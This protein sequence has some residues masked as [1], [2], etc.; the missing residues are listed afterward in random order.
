MAK[1]VISP[2]GSVSGVVELPGDKSI[3][4]RYA[5]L[6]ALAQGASEIFNYAS[7]A[8]CRSTLECLRRLGVQIDAGRDRVRIAGAGLDGL[9]ASRRPLDA[10]NS[11]STIRM[12]SGVLA[13]QPF[14]STLTGDASL[15][16]RP[17]RRVIDPLRQMGAAIATHDG[18]RAPL[19]IRGGRLL[20]ID[21]STPVPSAQVKSAILFAGLYADGVTAVRESIRTRD[22]TELALREFGA[23]LDVSK[24]GSGPH[25]LWV[26]RIHPRPKLAARQLTVPGDL[27]AAVFMI[28]AALVLPDSTLMLHTVG[29][30][31]TR[32]RVLDFLISIGAE[33]NI[34]SIQSRD[35]EL[36]G[37][38]AVRHATLEGGTI[39]G[40]QVAEMI[41]ELPM[42]AALGPFTEKGIEVR[43]AHELRVKESDRIAAL[44]A[45]LREMNARVEEFPDGLRV[46]GRSA[47]KLRGAKVDP[48]GDH[49]IAMAL[50]VAALGAEGDTTIRDADCAAVSFP[51]FFR[52]LARLRGGEA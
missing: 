46:E 39:A 37:D 12:L 40:P 25:P 27:S 47:G 34:A 50:A 26:A 9:K 1:Q 2:G 32:T 35:G 29:L 31:P 15:R 41:D 24:D 28:G 38:V 22:H 52:T 3:S 21:Y 19:E 45:G 8:D 44:A 13:G 17:M 16:R 48:H 49:R 5:I 14:A 30:N 18:D 6:A 7:A 43:D 33:I 10:E 36:I 42:L 23:S 20:A 4:H 51:E 11:G